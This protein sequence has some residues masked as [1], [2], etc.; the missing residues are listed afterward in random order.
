VTAIELPGPAAARGSVHLRRTRRRG[1][2]LAA[3]TVAGVVHA[4]GTTRIAY[5]SLGPRPLLAGDDTGLLA[6]P[7]APD[8]AK[9]GLLSEIFAGASPSP[10]SMRASPDYRVAMLHV[11][12]LR[13]V[14]TAIDRL[15]AAA[16]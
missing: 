14:R 6:D 4:D 9:A 11:L 1:H 2:D 13:A 8:E 3:V 15:A 16:R 10:R 5:G 12:G 7:S